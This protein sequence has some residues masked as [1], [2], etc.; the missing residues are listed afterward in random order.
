MKYEN[1]KYKKGNIILFLGVVIISIL[2]LIFFVGVIYMQVDIQLKTLKEDIDLIVRSC[3]YKNVNKDKLKYF[4]YEFNEDK[5]KEDITFLLEE[6][7]RYD[8]KLVRLSYDYKNNYFD[9]S[10]EIKFVPLIKI[11]KKASFK[12][13]IN[14]QV[15]FKLMEV[16]RNKN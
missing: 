7:Y 15:K 11:T 1:T 16:E 9:I 8:I 5:M 4:E 12:I 2:T 3:A 6:N 13:L 14:K 10:L